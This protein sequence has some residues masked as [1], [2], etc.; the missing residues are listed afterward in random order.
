[1]KKTNS[2][3][4]NNGISLQVLEDLKNS[5]NN[6]ENKKVELKNMTNDEIKQW[7]EG[8]KNANEKDIDCIIAHINQLFKNIFKYYLRPTQIISVLLLKKNTK[9]GRIAQILTGV[10]RQLLL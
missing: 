6:I 7:A 9:Y 5:F 2:N 10:G 4:K 1:M 3:R 8:I